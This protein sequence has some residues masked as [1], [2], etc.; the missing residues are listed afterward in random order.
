[1][2]AVCGDEC[3]AGMSAMGGMSDECE[4]WGCVR[5]LVE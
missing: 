5:G 1:M 3:E 2:S 4:A